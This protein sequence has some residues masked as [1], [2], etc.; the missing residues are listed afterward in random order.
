[1]LEP[2]TAM[3]VSLLSPVP[4]ETLP[5]IVPA[6]TKRVAAGGRALERDAAGDRARFRVRSAC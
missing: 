5:L 2:V 3:K 1:M 6:L 4:S